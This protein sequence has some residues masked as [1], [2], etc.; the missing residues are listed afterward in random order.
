ME[1]R[2][3]RSYDGN[4]VAEEERGSVQ[5]EGCPPP[6]ARP[7]SSPVG[8][9]RSHLCSWGPEVPMDLPLPTPLIAT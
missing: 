1:S 5:T 3:Q 8:N 2:W 7:S 6:A 9:Q 4:V